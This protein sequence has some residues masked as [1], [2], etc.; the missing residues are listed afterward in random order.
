MAD[1]ALQAEK[2]QSRAGM[3]YSLHA[4]PG[5]AVCSTKAWPTQ[6]PKSAAWSWEAWQAACPPASLLTT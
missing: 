5:L 4:E 3:P 6:A 1:Q 2:V